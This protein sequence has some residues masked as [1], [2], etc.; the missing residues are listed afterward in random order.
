MFDMQCQE[1]R[2]TVHNE[3]IKGLQG[4]SLEGNNVSMLMQQVKDEKIK[5]MQQLRSVIIQ[6]IVKNDVWDIQ[7][8][9]QD[10]E[11]Y[12]NNAIQSFKEKQLSF[13]LN[14]RFSAVRRQLDRIISKLFDEMEPDFWNT[15]QQEYNNLMED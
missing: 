13:F 4:L 6:S 11:N 12:I 9:I 5:T 15:L 8:I 14:T 7:T 1:L 2:K 3:F 10:F